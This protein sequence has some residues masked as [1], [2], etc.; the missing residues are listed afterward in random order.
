MNLTQPSQRQQRQEHV[1]IIFALILYSR[2]LLSVFFPSTTPGEAVAAS[3]TPI[4]LSIFLVI[5][6]ITGIALLSQWRAAINLALQEKCL[7][8]LLLLAALSPLW[9]VDPA[10]SI[11]K[12]VGIWA[13]TGF[14]LYLVLRFSADDVLVLLAIALGLV[15]TAS[16]IAA[17]FIP[18]IGV[19]HGV[20]EGLWSG[21]FSHKNYLATIS[22]V[23]GS[24]FFSLGL[25]KSPR[26][27]GYIVFFSLCTILVVMAGSKSAYISWSVVFVCLSVFLFINDR[28][29]PAIVALLSAGAM[30]GCLSLQMQYKMMPPLLVS[31]TVKCLPKKLSKPMQS[32]NIVKNVEANAPSS[33]HL[34]TGSGR[35][36]LWGHVWEQYKQR[37]TFG[38]GV[39]G[40]WLGKKGPSAYVWEREPWHPPH[41]H[42]GFIDVALSVGAVGFLLLIIRLVI[43][44]YRVL[45]AAWQRRLTTP[46]VALAAMLATVLL[47]NLGESVLLRPNSLVWI[48]LIIC[49]LFL[50]RSASSDTK[51]EMCKT[52]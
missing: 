36:R 29:H 43:A 49:M 34:D 16:F 40:F 46:A 11:E 39:G 18:S 3:D 52:S 32:C 1:F 37:P 42:N 2:A 23:G 28:I 26:R 14:G 10:E 9:S 5:Y 17:V 44:I 19:M 15:C 48:V 25:D 38:Y 27:W 20:H 33:A 35:L 7:T 12:M 22:S 47:R 45:T 41:A 6:A 50:E 30:L 8:L 4:K 21:V 51:Y 24:L 13:C 31:E